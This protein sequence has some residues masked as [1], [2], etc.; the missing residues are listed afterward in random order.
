M[1]GYFPKDGGWPAI[2][3]TTPGVI[4]GTVYKQLERYIPSIN[5]A[6]VEQ[7]G[8]LELVGDG[9]FPL[10]LSLWEALFLMTV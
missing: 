3:K 5:E 9:E 4:R 10:F 7:V 8:K 2:A 6:V 1:P